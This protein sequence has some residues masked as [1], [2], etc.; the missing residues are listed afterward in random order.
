MRCLAFLLLAGTGTVFAAPVPAVKPKPKDAPAAPALV[1][2]WDCN[3]GHGDAYR[4]D[5]HF[6]GGG[7]YHHRNGADLY[8]GT[9]LKNGDGTITVRERL[10]VAG[11]L[12]GGEKAWWFDPAACWDGAGRWKGRCGGGDY[13]TTA[14]GLRPA[15]KSP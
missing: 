5:M 12:V 13:G 9:W 7:D 10:M 11:E 14:F 6:G 2:M 15:K 1:G 8:V 4:D 3:W